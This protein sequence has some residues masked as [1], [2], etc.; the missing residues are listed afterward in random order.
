MAR[1]VPPRISE[2]AS[3][4]SKQLRA[5]ESVVERAEHNT[6]VG[7][8]SSRRSVVQVVRDHG[9]ARAGFAFEQDRRR[10]IT[11]KAFSASQRVP[12]RGAP[13]LRTLKRVH[14]RS[15]G[16]RRG[17]Q[18]ILTDRAARS[19][20]MLHAAPWKTRLSCAGD[21]ASGVQRATGGALANRTQVQRRGPT[22]SSLPAV[23]TPKT[24]HGD[25]IVCQG[26]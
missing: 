18:G 2:R 10:R 6:V 3:D 13:K 8:G 16:N 12:E 17:Q 7:R 15:T 22:W 21:P 14:G 1:S 5:G 9:L 25:S 20:R 23:E 24:R 26:R 4:V 19:R 11:S